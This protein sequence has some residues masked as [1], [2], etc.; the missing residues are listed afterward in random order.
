MEEAEKCGNFINNRYLNNAQYVQDIEKTIQHAINFEYFTGKKIL[1]LGAAGLIGSFLADCLIYA[2]GVGNVPMDIYVSSRRAENLEQRFGTEAGRL[3]F[4]E[5][6]VTALETKEPFDIIVNA[7]SAAHPAAFREKPVETMLANMLGTYR[8]LESAGK[9]PDC[10]VLYVSSG[11]VQEQIDHLSPRA[12]YPVSKKAG[13]TLCISYIQEYGTDIVIVRPCH[14]FGANFTPED[15]RAASQFIASAAAG[16][17]IV[18]KSAGGQM[19][20]FS[21]VA[22]CVSGILTAIAC[23]QAGSVYGIASGEICSLRQFAGICAETAQRQV[24]FQEVS[25][26][27]R[28]EASPIQMQ[29]IDNTELR[30][31]GWQP[32]FT[33]S[34][35]IEHAIRIRRDVW[36]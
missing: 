1:I 23:G 9:N 2:A 15:N 7:A 6:D 3:H 24:K 5:G 26:T 12:C 31:L 34:Q 14:T 20:S 11:E 22:D 25:E 17:D 36:R 33:L 21:Y 28:A 18:L 19:R 29:K 10:R 30:R 16:Q 4:M 27:E 13:E 8:V 35:G 32:C